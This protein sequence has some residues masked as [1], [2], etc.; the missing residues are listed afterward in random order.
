MI[1]P[2]YYIWHLARKWCG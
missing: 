1:L 2:W